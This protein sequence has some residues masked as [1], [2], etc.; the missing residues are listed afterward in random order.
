M[1][2]DGVSSTRSDTV[3]TTMVEVGDGGV[4]GGGGGDEADFVDGGRVGITRSPSCLRRGR[5][6]NDASLRTM[7]LRVNWSDG[8]CIRSK[9]GSHVMSQSSHVSTLIGVM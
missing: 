4:I 5:Y 2:G 6:G 3:G 7:G 8:P 9:P 1:P